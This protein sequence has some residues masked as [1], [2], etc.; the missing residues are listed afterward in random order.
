MY[1]EPIIVNTENSARA[2]ISFYFNG[3][4]QRIYSGRALGL[5][6]F[7]NRAKTY[8]ERI[9]SLQTLK[10]ELL[11]ALAA[12]KYPFQPELAKDRDVRLIIRQIQQLTTET[13]RVNEFHGL[14]I[15]QLEA[16]H[17]QLTVLLSRDSSIIGAS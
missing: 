17:D 14:H 4:R 10:A 1:T 12:D 2:Y 3:F 9:R 6:I 16:I 15:R 13:Q 7:P 5:K 11:K 8:K